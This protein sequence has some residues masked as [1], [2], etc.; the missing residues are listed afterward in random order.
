MI[1]EKDRP[2]LGYL[3]NIYLVL[4]DESRG[5]GFDLIFTFSQN[6]YF[7]GTEIKKEMIMKHKGILDRTVSTQ[8]EW[9]DACDPT[10]KK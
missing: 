5:E 2:I 6:G 1:S 8:I 3:I 7:K 10:K 4:H 9:K